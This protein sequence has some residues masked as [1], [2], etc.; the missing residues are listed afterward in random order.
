[1]GSMDKKHRENIALFKFGI[2]APVLNGNTKSQMKYFREVALKKY[3]VPYQGEKTFKA[4][5]FKT[6]LK[7]YRKDGI[8]GLM[9]KIR[10]D[11]GTSRKID[12]QLIDDIKDVYSRYLNISATAAYKILVSEG[13]IKTDGIQEQTLRKY[14]R[15]N[16]LKEKAI[17][18]PRKKYEKEHVNELW[19]ADA[20]HGPYIKKGK[21]KK[22]VF[23]IAA[24]DDHSRMITCYGWFF[25]E[26][27]IS[28]EI[29]LKEGFGRF[30]LPQVLYCD[31]GSI[32]S[33]SH[34]QLACARLGVALVHS[35]P[36]DSASRGKIERFFRTVRQK[37]LPFVEPQKIRDL[38]QINDYF[39]D[40]LEK[41]YTNEHHH[42]INTYPINRFME[43]LKNISIKRATEEELDLAFQITLTRKVKNDSTVSVNSVLYECPTKYIGKKIQI[44]HPS[45][46]PEELFIYENEKP[47][48]KLKIVDV[49]ANA[50]TP[51]LGI[52]FNQE[53]QKN[54]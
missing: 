3:D 6:W 25:N 41:E 17:K 51:T 39:K 16:N 5:T 14:I 8:E 34:L 7:K 10:K 52:K 36:Y 15:D 24:I 2:I 32:F 42:G 33:S 37:F 9:P 35:I 46:K 45:E 54:D 19:I 40:W 12:E 4:E 18:K 28:L 48:H 30:G 29:I 26:N 21:Q 44:R 38:V 27:S 49:H 43:D 50:N 20:M 1:M 11:K 31:N 23:L 13:K 22:K 47:K 53:E